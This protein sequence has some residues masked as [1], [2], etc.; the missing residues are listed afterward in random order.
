[1]ARTITKLTL[2]I[3]V[4]LLLT[5]FGL[6]RAVAQQVQTESSPSTGLNKIFSPQSIDGPL[7]NFPSK[8]PT[9]NLILFW[10]EPPATATGNNPP[11]GYHFQM[12]SYLRGQQSLPVDQRLILNDS[13]AGDSV[14]DAATGTDYPAIG[15]KN[16]SII[17]AGDMNGDST[18][19]V[20]SVWETADKKVLLLLNRW[21][22]IM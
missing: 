7:S 16:S 22:N 19:E 2:S 9:K 5:G 18:A 17:L 1:M 4:T 12:M 10:S 8:G 6:N 20:V 21:I 3:L 15:D 13:L 14:T 11:S